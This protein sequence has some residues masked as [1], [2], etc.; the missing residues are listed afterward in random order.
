MKSLDSK[1]YYRFRRISIRLIPQDEYFLALLYLTGSFEFSKDL[2]QIAK[3][4]GFMLNEYCLRHVH[5]SGKLNVIF[6]KLNLP[7]TDN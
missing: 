5:S 4:K 2:R 6:I 3:K 1:Q 7:L